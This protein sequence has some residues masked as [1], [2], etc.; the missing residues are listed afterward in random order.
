MNGKPVLA[1]ISGPTILVRLWS[2][3]WMLCHLINPED[4]SGTDRE[5]AL[6]YPIDH[7]VSLWI[8]GLEERGRGNDAYMTIDQDAGRWSGRLDS[9]QTR[10]AGDCPHCPHCQQK[11]LHSTWRD[12]DAE[13]RDIAALIKDQPHSLP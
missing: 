5:R 3:D 9:W 1:P 8:A 11:M 12:M 10:R 6:S 2:R 7:M 13:H 4:V